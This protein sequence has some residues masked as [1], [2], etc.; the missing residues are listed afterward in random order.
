MKI[1]YYLEMVGASGNGI[2]QASL[3]RTPLSP[4]LDALSHGDS[5]PGTWCSPG[6][7]QQPP[8]A[9]G[10]WEWNLTSILWV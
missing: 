6:C 1:L 5:Q 10:E 3:I 7:R 9:E 2:A 4:A 8:G